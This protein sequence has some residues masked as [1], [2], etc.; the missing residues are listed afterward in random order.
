MAPDN[1][2]ICKKCIIEKIDRFG[3][4]ESVRKKVELMPV[5][6]KVSDEEYYRRLEICTECK[7]LNLGMCNLCGCFVEY[8][9][10]Q[11]NMHCPASGHK[12]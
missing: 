4:L 3:I 9:A 10:A 7:D 1:Q 5:E 11:I 8:R 12:W 2:I 6:D